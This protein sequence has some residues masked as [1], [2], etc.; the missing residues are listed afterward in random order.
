[1]ESMGMAVKE[2]ND[3]KQMLIEKQ[4][5]EYQR[6]K[7]FEDRLKD[8]QKQTDQKKQNTEVQKALQIQMNE[9]NEK[10]RLLKEEVKYIVED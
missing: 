2:E 4:I 6:K 3:K 9:K 7:E 5:I 8:L 1:M 10:K